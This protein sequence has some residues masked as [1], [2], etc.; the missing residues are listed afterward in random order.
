[1]QM[2]IR[3]IDVRKSDLE[4]FSVTFRYPIQCKFRPFLEPIQLCFRRMYR[5]ERDWVGSDNREK[6]VPVLPDRPR[7]NLPLPGYG[8][9]SLSNVVIV[10]S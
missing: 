3:L 9:G 7:E 8:G 2:R 6:C 10:D 1:M 4:L 5:R